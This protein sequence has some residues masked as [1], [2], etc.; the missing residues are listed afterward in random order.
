VETS[1]DGRTDGAR[2]GRDEGR[3]RTDARGRDTIRTTRAFGW[4]SISAGTM[5]E[6]A[7]RA[8]DASGTLLNLKKMTTETTTTTTTRRRKGNDDDAWR[9]EDVRTRLEGA[10][11]AAAVVVAAGVMTTDEDDARDDDARVVE[12]LLRAKDE[13]D[14]ENDDVVARRRRAALVDAMSPETC[15]RATRRALAVYEKIFV[16]GVD[17][18]EKSYGSAPSLCAHRRARHPG[19]RGSAKVPT[20]SSV[21]SG[22]VESAESNDKAVVDGDAGDDADDADATATRMARKRGASGLDAASR[23]SAVG[24]YLEILAADAHD[25]L[26]TSLKSRRK[27]SR[28]MK[29]AVDRATNRDASVERRAVDACASRVFAS[30]ENC[31]DIEQKRASAW[32]D[33]LDNLSKAFRETNDASLRPNVD[34]HDASQIM[35]CLS[36]DV[37]RDIMRALREERAVAVATPDRR[38]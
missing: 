14:D 27:V 8:Q 20:S 18:C 38:E 16:C 32:L 5:V 36:H 12:T 2:R 35:A 7:R 31:I 11:D 23:S 15:G 17:G 19:W 4:K 10:F 21:V 30:M 29:E 13:D 34:K 28:A 9:G 3:D 37:A 26:N 25:R 22:I 24:A 1:D 33:T 6:D